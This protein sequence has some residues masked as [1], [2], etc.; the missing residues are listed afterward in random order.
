MPWQAI[1]LD[2]G[3]GLNP[4]GA[5][6]NG[7]TGNGTTE[8]DQVVALAEALLVYLRGLPLQVVPIGVT[9]VVSLADKVHKINYI[10]QS[11]H[12]GQDDALLVSLHM[13]SGAPNARGVEAYYGTAKV[14]G[15]TA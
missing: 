15:R 4:A 9:E 1:F 6:D 8:R 11:N 13:N 7:A 5:L 2:A 12:W 3:H 10:C 14:A